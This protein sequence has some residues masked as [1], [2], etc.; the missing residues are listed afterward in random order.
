MPQPIITTL[1]TEVNK[2]LPDLREAINGQG[3]ELRIISPQAFGELLKS[4]VEKWRGVIKAANI[5]LE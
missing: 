3:G 1:N 4:D 5:T 2:I